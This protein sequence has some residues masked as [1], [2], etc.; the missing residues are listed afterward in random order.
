MAITLKKAGLEDAEQLFEVQIRAFKPLLDKYQDYNT[1]PGAEKIETTI[2][3]LNEPNSHYYFIRLDDFN[4]GAVRITDW[5]DLC[6]LKQIYI[7][8]EYQNNGYAQEAVLLVE[9]IHKDAV[10]WE[11]DTIKQESKLCYL[12]EK[13]GYR[14]TGKEEK[15]KDEM[16]IISYRKIL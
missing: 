10:T 9:S 11:L 13:M 7:L 4:I 1:N 6:R 5:G 15:I 16:D 12:Y 3:R 8:P 2:R 14:K